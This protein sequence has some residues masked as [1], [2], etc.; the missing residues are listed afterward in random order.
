MEGEGDVVTRVGGSYVHMYIQY[1]T[2]GTEER[3]NFSYWIRLTHKQMGREK[4]KYQT[5]YR[6]I[7]YQITLFRVGN[8]GYPFFS[9]PSER[10]ESTYT[11]YVTNPCTTQRW[12]KRKVSPNISIYGWNCTIPAELIIENQQLQAHASLPN[13]SDSIVFQIQEV[14]SRS[15]R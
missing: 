4:M 9:G 15:T 10:Q 3:F 7:I 6:S 11:S 5:R 8:G 13:N 1:S 12:R 14:N 2:Y